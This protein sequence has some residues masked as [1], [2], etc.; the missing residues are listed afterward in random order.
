[1]KDVGECIGEIGRAGSTIF[2]TM[3]L[4]SGFWQLPLEQQSRGCTAFTCPGKGQFQYNVLSMGLKGGPGSFQ[5][6][7]ELAMMNLN[8]VI[9]YID[10]LLLHTKTHQQHREGLQRV[11]NR[12]RNINIKLNPEKCK[13]G[14]VNV[15]YLGFRLTPQGILPGTDKL[16]AVREMQPPSSITQVRQFLGLCNF[17][18]THVKNFSTIA[19]PLNRLTSKK[20]GWLG[21][22]LPP[23]ALE[24]FHTLKKALI[25][26][27]VVAYP[28]PDRQFSLIVDAATG[29]TET[30]GG[31][32]AIL[33]QPNDTGDL[34]V[35][36]YAS[37]SLKDHERN[38]T[39]YLAE[40]NAAAWAIDHFDV[41]L[42]GRRF[43]LYTDHKPLETMKTI[44]QKTMNRLMERLNMY[45]FDLQYKKGTEMPADILSRCPV[46]INATTF[47]ET[48]KQD[49]LQDEFCTELKAYVQGT[50][51]PSDGPKLQILKKIS[52][53]LLEEQGL[54]Y[55]ADP[56]GRRVLIL[57]RVRVPDII[58]QAH[59]TLLTGHGSIDKTLARLKS[60]YFWP[61]MRADVQQAITECDR[62]QKALKRGHALSKLHP[63]PLCT[64]TNQR[65]HCDLFGPLKTISSK[66]HVLC[67]TDAHTK[68]VELVMVPNKEAET[69]GKAIFNQWICRYGIPHQIL[70]DGGK[71]FCNKIFST[72]CDFLMIDKQKTTPAHPQCNAQAEVVNK[73]IKKYLAVMTENSLEW[74]ELIPALAF[75]YN[76]TQHRTTGMTPAEL[77]LGYLPRSMISQEIPQYSEDPIMDTLRA[78]QTARAIA[79]KEALRQTNTYKSDHDKRVQ[80]EI[81]YSPGQFVLLDRRLF[82][83]E[84]EK[85]SD[86]WEG[87]YVIQKVLPNGVVD[88]LRK[89]RTL[90]VNI[91]RLKHYQALSEI[92]PNYVLPEYTNGLLDDMSGEREKLFVKNDP[93]DVSITS[94]PSNGSTESEI[95]VKSSGISEFPT[96]F[97]QTKFGRHP[98]VL[99][100]RQSLNVISSV[101]K[102]AEKVSAINHRVIAA[103]IRSINLLADFTILDEYGLPIQ[104][105]N[106]SQ[107]QWIRRRRKYLKSLSPAQRNALLTGDPAFVFDPL[108]YEYV[109][110]TRRP[111]LNPQLLEYFG[112]LPGIKE[113]K[114][115]RKPSVKIEPA[116][117]YMQETGLSL[118]EEEHPSKWQPKPDPMIEDNTFYDARSSHSSPAKTI[119]E[120]PRFHEDYVDPWQAPWNYPATSRKALQH[121]GPLQHPPT[122]PWTRQGS[123]RRLQHD[124]TLR[125]SS[126]TGRMERSA[127]LSNPPGHPSTLRDSV[128]RPGVMNPMPPGI[129]TS[130]SYS[131]LGTTYRPTI[132]FGRSAQPT[133]SVNPGASAPFATPENW[134]HAP[135]R[136]Q[137][138]NL[139]SISY[140]DASR[141]PNTTPPPGSIP[142]MSWSSTFAQ[143]DGQQPFDSSPSTPTGMNFG[144][145]SLEHTLRPQQVKGCESSYSDFSTPPKAMECRQTIN[146]LDSSEKSFTPW[147]TP[148]SGSHSEL[149]S[150]STPTSSNSRWTQTVSMND[151]TK[152]S[153]LRRSHSA[154]QGP[155]IIPFRKN[156]SRYGMPVQWIRTSTNWELQQLGEPISLDEFPR[157][158]MNQQPMKEDQTQTSQDSSTS[159]SCVPRRKTK[160]KKWTAT[161]SPEQSI[162]SDPTRNHCTAI[163]HNCSKS[164]TKTMATSTNVEWPN[165]LNDTQGRW[166]NAWP[167]KTLIAQ[168]TRSLPPNYGKYESVREDIKGY[169]CNYNFYGSMNNLPKISTTDHL[170][171]FMGDNRRLQ[172]I[173]KQRQQQLMT[174]SQRSLG[175]A[176]LGP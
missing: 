25:S 161:R 40:M 162:A 5:R 16:K 10:D 50:Y 124:Q 48:L 102:D 172:L 174:S 109:W 121:Q 157:R 91:H 28:R 141:S 146:S 65:V 82:V 97:Q 86:K 159:C 42:R 170:L 153:S 94:T 84:N 33:C 99:R 79:N 56:E 30:K 173:H 96:S 2:S 54:L 103:H 77:M 133:G 7:M 43:T 66:A 165:W 122:I 35:V 72:I 88:I 60:Q 116:D 110:S 101:T 69:V 166:Q 167:D 147:T 27:P 20:T 47:N 129:S 160:S 148:N 108:V 136:T 152:D 67:I 38:Y 32:G 24:A 140:Q 39:P 130:G 171:A 74:E 6:M 70:T 111:P 90:R 52:P 68:Y 14:A 93:S 85:L 21:G 142:I 117:E 62:C 139:P 169:E 106:Q 22:K 12:L 46:E 53:F 41:Y 119:P 31:F 80:A 75:S 23:D 138:P 158:P 8:D 73:S 126:S 105:K 107:A 78:F 19:S 137:Q 1:M 55:L 143:S 134:Y 149:M 89:G 131:A 164:N 44:H 18:R 168:R 87:P 59:G 163:C 49:V 127:S 156:Q 123:L 104:V 81:T 154:D 118:F 98:M 150:S 9:V 37:R 58:S 15:S 13:F 115:E 132:R 120:A 3:D 11:F 113:F 155:L 128:I 95:I 57:P 125:P 4:T 26:N 144:V 92:R 135:S 29:G 145:N 175:P 64:E 100:K 151:L 17:F 63:L 71:E 114:R 51:S 83:N 45:D 61:F 36:A 76:T 34:Q 176:C 112:H